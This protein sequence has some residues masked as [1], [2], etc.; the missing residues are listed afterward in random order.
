MIWMIDWRLCGT[1]FTCTF[2]IPVCYTGGLGVETPCPPLIGIMHS[3]GFTRHLHVL[4]IFRQYAGGAGGRNFMFFSNTGIVLN[5][6]ESYV[7][8]G[9]Q[10][11][12]S[13]FV[14]LFV[15]YLCATQILII[16][17]VATFPLLVTN[18]FIVGRHL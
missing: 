5:L 3:D 11:M 8:I 10:G 4:F 18:H 6:W 12:C 9:A 17:K 1:P 7:I 15:L 13:P 16:W 14:S 2:I